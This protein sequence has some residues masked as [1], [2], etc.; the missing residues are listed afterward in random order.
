VNEVLVIVGVVVV[1]IA[2]MA[3]W[4]WVLGRMESRAV[5]REA[6]RS[7]GGALPDRGVSPRHLRRRRLDGRDTG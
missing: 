5:R 3:L 1:V 7:W 6:E 2:L 4:V